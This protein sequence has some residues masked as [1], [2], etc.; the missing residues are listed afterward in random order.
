MSGAPSPELSSA[1]T[2]P[3]RRTSA[4]ASA[5]E[6]SSTDVAVITSNNAAPMTFAARVNP[7]IAPGRRSSRML[8]RAATTTRAMSRAFQMTATHTSIREPRSVS[9]STSPSM[10]TRRR[11]ITIAAA[12]SRRGATSLTMSRRSA[13]A[14]TAMRSG[15]IMIPSP[16]VVSRQALRTYPATSRTG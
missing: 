3:A 13:T 1:T 6:P 2:W 12:P 14:M 11:V 9:P 4:N 15:R 7:A 10:S 5:A 16:D 8:I